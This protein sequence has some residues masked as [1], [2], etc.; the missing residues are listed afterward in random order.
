MIVAF[1]VSPLGVGEDVGEYVADA[2]RVV[3]ESGLPNRTDAMFTSIEGESWDEVMDVVKR[4]VA[5]VEA[6]AGRV[7]L[8]L[9]ADI[10]PGVTD[11]LTSKVET[12]ERYLAD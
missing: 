9:K 12:V 10:R 4:A 5:A 6:R 8:V 3:R 1:S 2:V 7:S 11:G